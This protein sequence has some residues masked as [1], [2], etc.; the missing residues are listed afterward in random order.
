MIRHYGAHLVK[1]QAQNS[2][3]YALVCNGWLRAWESLEG[4]YSGFLGD[5]AK[6]REQA[7]QVGDVAVQVRCALCLSSVTAMSSNFSPKLLAES[8][9]SGLL[10]PAQAFHL[11]TSKPSEADRAEALIACATAMPQLLMVDVVEAVC[12]FGDEK[13]RA[14]ALKRLSHYLPSSRLEGY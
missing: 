2:E 5:I 12:S 1:G 10:Q 13:Q 6:A 9:E 4:T 14:E 7:D 11:A 3:I 8:L